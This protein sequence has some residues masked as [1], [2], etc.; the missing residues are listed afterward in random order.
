MNVTVINFQ[1]ISC[2]FEAGTYVNVHGGKGGGSRL[3]S[4]SV[5]GLL[6][7]PYLVELPGKVAYQGDCHLIIMGNMVATAYQIR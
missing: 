7:T 4:R 2:K 3:L 1:S 5:S 6:P